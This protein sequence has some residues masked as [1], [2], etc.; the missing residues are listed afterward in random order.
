MPR[1]ARCTLPL[2][3]SR[4]TKRPPGCSIAR[5]TVKRPSPKPTST[6]SGPPAENTSSQS[7]GKG[8]RRQGSS[9]S[10]TVGVT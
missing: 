8:R 2:E 7:T 5:L 9:T 1:N 4:P 6:C 3:T 10:V